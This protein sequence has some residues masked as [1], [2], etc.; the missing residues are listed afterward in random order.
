[1]YRV[2]THWYFYDWNKIG[3]MMESLGSHTR[4]IV[5]LVP[6]KD[7]D[8]KVVICFTSREWRW[9][10]LFALLG[11]TN[12]VVDSVIILFFFGTTLKLSWPKWRKTY[13]PVMRHTTSDNSSRSTLIA[14]SEN[15]ERTSNDFRELLLLIHWN[16][17]D[18]S[19]EESPVY[20]YLTP[21]VFRKCGK[22]V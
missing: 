14:K 18:I 22:R 6:N 8:F 17:G 7:P 21:N 10:W 12:V 13:I 1:M 4:H 2:V 3:Y 19:L 9:R 20:W 16:L 11:W 15:M 5:V